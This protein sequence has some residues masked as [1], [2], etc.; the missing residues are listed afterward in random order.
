[1]SMLERRKFQRTQV[2]ARARIILEDSSIIDCTVR[3]LTVAGAGILATP[4][5]DISDRF[6]LTFDGARSLRPC[7]LIWRTRDRLGV[8]FLQAS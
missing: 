4:M 1:M 3:D 6:D 2:M 7:R 5:T 8:E